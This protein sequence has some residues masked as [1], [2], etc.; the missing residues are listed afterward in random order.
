MKVI[1]SKEILVDA[2]NTVQKAVSSKTTLPILEGILLEAG[3][4]FKLT[5]TDLE[6]GI[7]YVMDADIRE[8][9]AV[10]LNS[11]IFGDIAR[12]LPDSEILI[13]VGEG[14]STVMIESDTSRFEINGMSPSGYPALPEVERSNVFT[15]QENKLKEIIRQ[16]IFAVSMDENRPILTG[17]LFEVKEGWFNIVSIDGYRLA[18]RRQEAGSDNTDFNAVVPGKTLNEL[19]K[20]MGDSEDGVS[21]YRTYNQILFEMKKCKVY[22]RLLEGE[23]LNYRNIIPGEYT[24]NIKVNT[25]QLLSGIERVSLMTREDR[26]YPIKFFIQGDR[27]IMT[28]NTDIGSAKEELNVESSGNEM[29][30]GFNPRYFIDTLK[31]IDEEQVMIGFISNVGPCVVRPLEAES[32]AYMILPVRLRSE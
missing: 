28:T 9:G 20:I 12:K 5:A 30:I 21:I 10:V 14:S 27:L 29:E 13:E 15:V 25:K 2:I 7:E 1:C 16:T 23:F 8:Q 6:I 4:N 3:S 24:L 31:V 17:S 26:K 19:L 18:M 32:F 11:R 22:S